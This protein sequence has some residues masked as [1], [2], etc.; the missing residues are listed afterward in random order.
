MD[1]L[2]PEQ[3][4]KNMQAIKNKRT[5]IEELLG[6][7]LWAIGYRYRRNN[8]TVFGKPDFTFRKYKIAVFCDS[9]FFHGKDWE[10][11]KH[12]I[13]TNTEFWQEKIE[14][15]IRRDQLVNE[16]LRKDGW[17]VIRFWGEEIKK[18]LDLCI[19]KIELAIEERKQC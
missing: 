17:I 16:T 19:D 9:E 11:S 2:T 14:R 12:R 6:K 3:R 10:V 8:K 4:R 13:K 15:N 18:N 1:V 7:A 5:K